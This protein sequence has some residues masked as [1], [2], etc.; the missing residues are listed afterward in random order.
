VEAFFYEKILT[1]LLL[2]KVYKTIISHM[3][4]ISERTVYEGQWL[5]VH[6]TVC[7]SKDGKQIVW[8][9]IRRR[10]STV[11]VVVL[12][13]LIPSNQIILIKQYRPAIGGYI[14]AVPAGLGFDDPQHALVELKE[15]TG[16]SGQI[17]SVSPVLKTGAS[18]VDDSAYIVCV[19]VDENAKENLNPKQELEAGEDIEVCL[20]QAEQAMNFLLSQQKQGVHIAANLWYLFGVSHWIQHV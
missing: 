17:I 2:L 20:V 18:L 16:Y 7:Q 4:K 14:L 11:G 1:V 9:S 13:R 3:K 6:E 19:N 5:S 10:K 8:E 12:A 15:E